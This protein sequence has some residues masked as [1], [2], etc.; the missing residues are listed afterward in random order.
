M[1]SSF[2]PYPFLAVLLQEQFML[3]LCFIFI[4]LYVY[5]SSFYSLMSNEITD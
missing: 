4:S 1:Y 5:S 3:L 2:K